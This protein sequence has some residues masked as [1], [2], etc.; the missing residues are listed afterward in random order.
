MQKQMAEKGS[1]DPLRNFLKVI[2]Y[3]A[4]KEC[5]ISR[6]AAGLRNDDVITKGELQDIQ[7]SQL[8]KANDLFYGIL[9]RD[10]CVSKLKSFSKVLKEDTTNE[11]HTELAKKI[12]DFL[13]SA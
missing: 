5:D 12:D 6:V 11:C 3:Q 4:L 1:N 2:L 8:E 13:L 10:L 9:D 7:E